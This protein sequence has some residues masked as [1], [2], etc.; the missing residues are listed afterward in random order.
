[1]REMKV[2]YAHYMF[3]T[4]IKLLFS[5]RKIEKDYLLYFARI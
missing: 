1:M 3:L 4:K 2:F 5:C